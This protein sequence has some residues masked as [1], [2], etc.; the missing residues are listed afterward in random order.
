MISPATPDSDS[1][2]DSDPAAAADGRRVSP[3][4]RAVGT[5]GARLVFALLP[6]TQR[7]CVTRNGDE[8]FTAAADETGIDAAVEVLLRACGDITTGARLSN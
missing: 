8:I 7:C 1:D 2:S 4:I 3:L 5:D 6:E